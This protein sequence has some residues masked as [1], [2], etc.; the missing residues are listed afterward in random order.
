M[1]AKLDVA[2]LQAE[3]ADGDDALANFQPPADASPECK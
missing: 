1:A 2:R 3:L